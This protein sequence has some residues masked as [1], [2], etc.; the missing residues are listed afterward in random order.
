[1]HLADVSSERMMYVIRC[2]IGLCGLDC[3]AMGLLD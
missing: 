3:S 1:V 2:V